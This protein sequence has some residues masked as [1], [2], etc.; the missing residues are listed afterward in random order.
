MAPDNRQAVTGFTVLGAAVGCLVLAFVL[1]VL[2]W[3]WLLLLVAGVVVPGWALSGGLLVLAFVLWRIGAAARRPARRVLPR[4]VVAVLAVLTGLGSLLGA[5]G[6]LSADY[7]VLQPSSPHGCQVVV[8]ETAFLFAGSGQVYAVR[9]GVGVH[10]GSWTADDG[11]RPVGRGD[12]E[13]RW[14]ADEGT[15]TV[16]GSPGN[17]VWPGLHGLG[18]R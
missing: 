11:D 16:H 9:F 15:F 4:W 14:G 1:L 13:L 3:S 10:R 18:C 6:D 8:R 17:P 12:Y 5:L 7:H 2:G